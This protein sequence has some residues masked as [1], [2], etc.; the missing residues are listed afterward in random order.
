MPREAGLSSVTSRLP[1]RPLP[2][3]GPSSPARIR[4]NVVLPEPEGPRSA[5]NSPSPTI[6]D[7]SSSAGYA[8]KLFETRSILIDIP[9]SVL[10]AELVSVSPLERGLEREGDDGKERE[11]RSDGERGDKVV[12]IVK[13]LYLKRH[14]VGLAANV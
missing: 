8:E 1:N 14:G 13:G 12:V 3:A 5:T 9:L 10:S 2:R 6:I 11:E 7:T 4:S